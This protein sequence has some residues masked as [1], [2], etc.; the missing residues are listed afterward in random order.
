V[1]LLGWAGY[2]DGLQQAFDRF[3]AV[4]GIAV[5]FVGCRNQDEFGTTWRLGSRNQGGHRSP[6]E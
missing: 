1:R 2:D 5:E 3:A 4:S 6:D